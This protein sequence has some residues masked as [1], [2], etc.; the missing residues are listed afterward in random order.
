MVILLAAAL[1]CGEELPGAEVVGKAFG[2]TLVETR[3]A[4]SGKRG[5]ESIRAF[6][7]VGR[8]DVL[9][10]VTMA[11]PGTFLNMDLRALAEEHMLASHRECDERARVAPQGRE[12][13]VRAQCEQELDVVVR[14]PNRRHG[15]ELDTSE[16]QKE[17]RSI[18]F[19]SADRRHDVVLKISFPPK[20]ELPVG[21]REAAMRLDAAIQ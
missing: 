15:Y 14:F 8:P 10:T 3:A 6:Q 20:V 17:T 1:L 19:E 7:M 9:I 18:T 11:A 16:R 4:E 13:D 5:V 12:N 21:I 2:L